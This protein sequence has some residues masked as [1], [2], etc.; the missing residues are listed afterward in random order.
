ML[1]GLTST[2]LIYTFTVIVAAYVV[3]GIVG[4]GSGLIAIPLLVI[5]LPLALVVPLVVTL[6]YIASASQGLKNREHINWREIFP[7]L[8]F[9]I[10]GVGLALYLL[11]TVDAKLLMRS[12]GVFILL[13]AL[14]N[15]LIKRPPHNY[16]RRWAAPAGALGGLVG[17]LFGTGGPFYVIYL[18]LR[19][20]EKS[21]FRA[22]FAAIFLLDGTYRIGGYFLTGF[23]NVNLLLLLAVTLPV[24]AVSIYLGGRIHTTVSQETFKRGISLLLLASG[25]ALLLK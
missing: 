14:Y 8:P 3:R 19:S 13:Y 2:Q 12:L 16:S 18:Q 22:T 25:A 20:L 7:L 9:T 11:K 23:F 1:I 24:M 15:L 17:T 6:D 5:N 10:L 4:F 21:Q